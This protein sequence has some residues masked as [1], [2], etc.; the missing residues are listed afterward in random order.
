MCRAPV[1]GVKAPCLREEPLPTTILTS[2]PQ[3]LAVCLCGS[4]LPV[5]P[6]WVQSPECCLMVTHRQQYPKSPAWGRGRDTPWLL[7]SNPALPSGWLLDLRVTSVTP[8]LSHRR[9]LKLNLLG[10]PGLLGTV[11]SIFIL[12]YVSLFFLFLCPVHLMCYWD[13]IRLLASS[14]AA[15]HLSLILR[16]SKRPNLLNL[17]PHLSIHPFIHPSLYSFTPPPIHLPTH[18]PIHPPT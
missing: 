1:A 9:N 11:V 18:P 4:D 14:K 7:P 2:P 16:T 10:L 6:I 8:M 13:R 5:S 17:W 12:F 15:T 3:A